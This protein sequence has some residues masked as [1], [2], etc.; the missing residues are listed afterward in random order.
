MSDKTTSDSIDTLAVHAGRPVEQGT[1][2]VTPAV[3]LSTTYERDADGGYR[4]GFQYV[5]DGNPNRE[6]LEAGIAALEGADRAVA[7]SSG[8]AATL[9]LFQTAARR[10]AVV[11]TDA[12]YHGTLRQLREIV[13]D[14]GADVRLVDTCSLAA[15]AELMSED[16][17]LLFV[18][19][20]SNPLLGISDIPGLAE[21]ADKHG[22]V[23]ACDNTFATPILQRPLEHG[24]RLVVHS[25]TKYIGGHS[26]VM[27][28]ILAGTD[29][30][31]MEELG[32]LRG[33]AGAAPSPFDCWL[34]QRS[35]PTL[36]LR[37]RRQGQS[38]VRVAEFLAG[39]DAVARVHYPGLSD[40]PGHTVAARQMGGFGGMISFQVNGGRPAA[41][42]VAA[43]A[44]LFTRATSLGGVESLI[45]HRASIEGPGTRTPD[46]LLRLSIGL[47]DV[48]ALIEDL[49]EALG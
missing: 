40:H 29:S 10:G 7:F 15:V 17:A 38:A 39:H 6:G 44:R 46:D 43:R 5:R 47:E 22:A 31:W 3:H 30:G 48:K 32:Q 8:S 4:R 20:P 37:V 13:P 42:A 18:E 45:E 16:V 36:P 24:A 21:L 34:L 23:L 49:A 19:T 33:A 28:G 25:S 12:S 1:G 41:M 35:L 2:D 11:A 26:D 9:A 27:G 14:F